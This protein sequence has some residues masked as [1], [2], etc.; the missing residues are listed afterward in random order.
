MEEK[1]PVTVEVGYPESSSRILALIAIPFFIFKGI[2]LIPHMII[3]Q[4]L[5]I[6]AMVAVWFAYWAILFTGKYPKVLFDFVVGVTRWQ[7]R[8]SAWMFS[9]TDKYPPFRF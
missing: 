5:Q 6:A 8:T 3:L 7:T 1:Y 9:L 2:L 4:F